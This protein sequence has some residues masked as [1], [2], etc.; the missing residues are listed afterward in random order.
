MEYLLPLHYNEFLTWYRL[1]SNRILRARLI[2]VERS[3]DGS[4]LMDDRTTEQVVGALPAYEDDWEVLVV[5]LSHGPAGRDHEIPYVAYN[6]K[7]MRAVYPIS[8]RGQ[9]MV[10]NRLVGQAFVHAPL[11]EEAVAAREEKNHRALAFR[12]GN[13]ALAYFGLTRHSERL[14]QFEDEVWQA[15]RKRHQETPFPVEDGTF[16]D[17]LVCYDRRDPRYPQGDLGFAFD[18]GKIILEHHGANEKVKQIL[19]PF[20]QEGLN[21]LADDKL[22]DNL[23]HLLPYLHHIQESVD[24]DYPL[25][26]CIAFLQMQEL[27]RH[28][29]SLTAIEGVHEQLMA[30]ESEP[31]VAF[32]LWLTGCFYDFTPFAQEYYERMEAPF[33]KPLPVAG[34]VEEAAKEADAVNGKPDAE[35]AEDLTS[36]TAKGE[37][38]KCV[39]RAS[40]AG[41]GTLGFGDVDEGEDENEDANAGSAVADLPP[42]ELRTR[43]NVYGEIDDLVKVPGVGARSIEKLKE[44]FE[45]IEGVRSATKNDLIEIL[46]PHKGQKLH[47]YLRKQF[48]ESLSYSALD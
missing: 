9:R 46:G 39:D 34:A 16:M 10:S 3:P 20:R 31:E 17:N 23:A 41:Q 28:N 48:E 37:D 12:G 6:A 42:E 40:G 7:D 1:G 36:L 32:A 44:K 13:A 24:I 21:E 26:G 25:V 11:C 19:R 18:L 43:D 38:E 29:L 30:R 33:V 15:I 4:L 14:E 22:W 47:A 27:L 5:L 35:Q 45:S 2:P 8:T